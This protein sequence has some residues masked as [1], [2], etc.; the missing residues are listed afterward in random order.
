MEL[1]QPFMQRGRFGGRC[2]RLVVGGDRGGGFGRRQVGGGGD[3]QHR[4]AILRVVEQRDEFR[5]AADESVPAARHH[6]SL[7]LRPGES[8]GRRTKPG[9]ERLRHVG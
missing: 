2:D 7:N 5:P 4:G 8:L 1:A 3:R 9:E 6:E